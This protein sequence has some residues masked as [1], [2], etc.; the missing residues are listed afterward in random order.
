MAG[1][2]GASKLFPFMAKGNISGDLNDATNGIYGYHK[3][4]SSST[5]GPSGISIGIFVCFDAPETGNG[6][7]PKLQ[8]VAT[9][10][11]ELTIAVYART[12]WSDR[13]TDWKKMI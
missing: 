11:T 10:T 2:L 7:N 13:W 6:G 3:G 4:V 8:I 1:L 12:K 9:E 5:N